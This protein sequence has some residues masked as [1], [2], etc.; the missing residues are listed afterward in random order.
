MFRR[1]A[2]SWIVLGK[3]LQSWVDYQEAFSIEYP[4]YFPIIAALA[5]RDSIDKN[6]FTLHSILPGERINW[7]N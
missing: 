2:N 3:L 1:S 6:R 4:F 7:L 5:A